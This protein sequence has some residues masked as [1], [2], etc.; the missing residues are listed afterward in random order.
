M[1]KDKT[2]VLN[3]VFVIKITNLKLVNYNVLTNFVFIVYQ[4]GFKIQKNVQFVDKKLN[5]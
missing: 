2:K 1:K 5:L 4:N 3:V